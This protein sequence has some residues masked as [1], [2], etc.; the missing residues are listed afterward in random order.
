MFGKYS[1]FYG[2]FSTGDKLYHGTHVLPDHDIGC[3]PGLASVSPG[4]IQIR[5]VPFAGFLYSGR[6][7][8][9]EGPRE[10]RL[11]GVAAVGDAL[12]G[13][14]APSSYRPMSCYVL[15]ACP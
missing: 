15:P 13:P 12:P 1:A 11:T 4:S 9:R 7:E 10:R 3:H 8:P 2:E 5:K 14:S 6:G